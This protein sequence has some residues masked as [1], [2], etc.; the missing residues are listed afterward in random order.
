MGPLYPQVQN[1]CDQ[2]LHPKFLCTLTIFELGT[3]KGDGLGIDP[4]QIPRSN[5]TWGNQHSTSIPEHKTCRNMHLGWVSGTFTPHRC[6][7]KKLNLQRPSQIKQPMKMNVNTAKKKILKGRATRNKMRKNRKMVF[8]FSFQFQF[9]AIANLQFI[10]KYSKSCME[11]VLN[12]K[13]RSY[14]NCRGGGNWK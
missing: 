9:K 14:L 12:F 6:L 4:L 7:E 10:S 1:Q 11:V 13:I 5:C 2:K 8:S 3:R